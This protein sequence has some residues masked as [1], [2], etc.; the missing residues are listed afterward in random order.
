MKSEREAPRSVLEVRPPV[1][2]FC[3]FCHAPVGEHKSGIYDLHLKFLA[4]EIAK[5]EIGP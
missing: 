3:P 4:T 1:F 5:A 2:D